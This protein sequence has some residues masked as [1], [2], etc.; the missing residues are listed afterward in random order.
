MMNKVHLLRFDLNKYSP[1]DITK[2]FDNIKSILTEEDIL[3]GLPY[4]FNLDL[5]IPVEGLIEIRNQLNEIID[6]RT[7][8]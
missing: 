1:E 5:D 4:G 2:V 3:I 8:K 7:T 6:E